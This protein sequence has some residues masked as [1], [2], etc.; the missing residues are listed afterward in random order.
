MTTISTVLEHAKFQNKQCS[1]FKKQ[2]KQTKKS[3]EMG[4]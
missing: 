2:T 4:K 1:G 3:W